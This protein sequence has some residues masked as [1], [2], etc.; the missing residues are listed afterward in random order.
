MSSDIFVCLIFCIFFFFCHD[1]SIFLVK[2][3]VRCFLF[4]FLVF[5]KSFPLCV[6]CYLTL[7]FPVLVVHTCILSAPVVA[8]IVLCQSAFPVVCFGY[9]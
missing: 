2:R 1:L 7:L 4:P 8:L 9:A 3:F 6:I 5:C